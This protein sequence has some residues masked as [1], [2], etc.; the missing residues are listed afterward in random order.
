MLSRYVSCFAGL[1]L[2]GLGL[3]VAT[4]AIGRNSSGD[5]LWA[6]MFL[7]AGSVLLTAALVPPRSTNA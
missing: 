2:W 7:L 6:A 4:R 3:V 5:W 1:N